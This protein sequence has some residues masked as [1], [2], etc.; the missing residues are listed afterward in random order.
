MN[1]IVKLVFGSQLYGTSSESSDTDYKGIYLPSKDDCYLNKIKNSITI[2]SG[3]NGMKNS[4][5]DVDEDYYSLQHFMKLGLNGEMIVLD[6]LH[7]PDNMI[8]DNSDIWSYLRSNRSKFYTKNL[9][10]YLG[11]IR[12][13]TNK[14][15]M[16]G[17][18]LMAMKDLLGVLSSYTNRRLE[19]F[20]DKLP[21]NDF[22]FYVNIPKSTVRSYS[23]CGKVLQGTM[24]SEYAYEIVKKHYESYGDRAKKAEKNEGIDW[25][26]VSHAFRACYQ[27]LEIYRTGNLVFP[28]VDA[29]FLKDV[30]YGKFH[31][32]KDGIQ[33]RLDTLLYE[34][35]YFSKM[36]FYPDRVD[37]VWFDKFIID[38][39]GG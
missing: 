2:S 10:G 15:G 16:K 12:K 8:I 4:S 33:E 28:L 21:I 31:Y 27:L 38:C 6:M 26:A 23:F 32:V 11:Y 24:F 5:N 13:Q 30:K 19:T 22:C 9:A 3:K 34:V 36:S 1:K 29:S 35:E 7:A 25:K 14:Y 39:Y 20:W 17:E 37:T 18:R